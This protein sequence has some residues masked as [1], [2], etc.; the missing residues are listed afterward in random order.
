MSQITRCPSCQTH[1]KVVADQLR[2]SQGWVRC[3][4]CQEVFDASDALLLVADVSNDAASAHGA[5]EVGSNLVMSP[6]G[7]SPAVQDA[8]GFGDGPAAVTAGHT[9]A[10]PVASS[11]GYS[12]PTPDDALDDEV[13]PDDNGPGTSAASEPG[14]GLV[15]MRRLHLGLLWPLLLQR[16]GRLYG[17]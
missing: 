17:R 7:A 8:D 13:W 11:P 2:I 3:G 9:D 6:P 16:L 10:E 5:H 1:F 15:G 12:L 4:Q 14:G